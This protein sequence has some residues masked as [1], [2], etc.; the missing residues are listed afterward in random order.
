MQNDFVTVLQILGRYA[1][2][3]MGAV[4]GVHPAG[5]LAVVE[6]AQTVDRTDVNSVV[7]VVVAGRKGDVV[8]LCHSL[9][10]IPHG[11]RSIRFHTALACPGGQAT[12][13]QTV[14]RFGITV[15]RV[16]KDSDGDGNFCGNRL[17]GNGNVGH[18]SAVAQRNRLVA[19]CVLVIALDGNVAQGQGT[20]GTI[21]PGGRQL[22]AVQ[23]QL[24]T[25]VIL[26]L[27]AAADRQLVADGVR[28][29]AADLLAELV[30]ILTQRII[31]TVVVLSP[32]A[33]LYSGAVFGSTL[34]TEYDGSVHLGRIGIAGIQVLHETDTPIRTA[35]CGVG[36][37]GDV[38]VPVQAVSVA[39]D[40]TDILAAADLAG[41][42]VGTDGANHI[43]PGLGHKSVTAEDAADTLVAF[44]GSVHGAGQD[45]GASTVGGGRVVVAAADDTTGVG[46]GGF[47]GAVERRVFDNALGHG[48]VSGA[49]DAAYIVIALDCCGAGAVLDGTLEPSGKGTNLALCPGIADHNIALDGAVADGHNEACTGRGVAVASAS[50][51]QTGFQGFGAAF[52]RYVVQDDGAAGQADTRKVIHKACALD[53][54]AVDIQVL[55]GSAVDAAQQRLLACRD[56]QFLVVA[57]NMAREGGIPCAN[58]RPVRGQRNIVCD[59]EV[60]PG[61]G[62]A[63]SDHLLDF[64]QMLRCFDDVGVLFRTSAVHGHLTVC[65]VD[66]QNVRLRGYRFD[67]GIFVA[68]G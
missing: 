56:R 43:V 29:A 33:A 5:V 52:Q 34:R 27:V 41:K 30:R 26:G 55:D 44:H 17:D 50:R 40:G 21:C 67:G 60:G 6:F 8:L 10:D 57:V 35:A 49:D 45:G 25:K 42:A 32:G 4:D 28:G 47:Y 19:H 39:D 48:V 18:S 22:D 61:E 1:H 12:P 20:G 51:Y 62:I 7:G 64:R 37:G 13:G 2:F 31:S 58:R 53:L 11:F 59:L 16:S 15:L 36:I 9:E 65:E 3:G 46:T 66:F 54:F 23:V 38:V 24:L 14:G 68:G 63:V